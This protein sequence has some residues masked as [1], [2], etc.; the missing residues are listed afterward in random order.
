MY[1]NLIPVGRHYIAV[2]KSSERVYSQVLKLTRYENQHLVIYRLAHKK[3]N[4]S[5]DHNSRL[6]DQLKTL[7]VQ[8]TSKFGKGQNPPLKKPNYTETKN[9]KYLHE[10]NIFNVIRKVSIIF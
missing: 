4:K 6:F 3:V 7:E 1:R 2:P 8:Y 5:K 9:N 10:N